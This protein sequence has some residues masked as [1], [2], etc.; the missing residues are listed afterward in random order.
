MGKK[1]GVTPTPWRA[2]ASP[3]PAT[4]AGTGLEFL[5]STP[6]NEPIAPWFLNP[7]E[8]CGV[9]RRAGRGLP[10]GLVIPLG[11]DRVARHEV[12]P[13]GRREAGEDRA[14]LHAETTAQAVTP[15][16][17]RSGNTP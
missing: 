15:R 14:S 8:V 5:G 4:I 3:P 17:I 16:P 6:V 13:G 10:F 1:Y 7:G 11:R 9:E 2:R 12:R